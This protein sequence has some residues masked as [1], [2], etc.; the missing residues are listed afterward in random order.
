[1][2]HTNIDRIWWMWQEA[3]PERLYE[4]EGPTSRTPPYGNITLHYPLKMGNVGPT[5]PVG[6]VMD[7]RKEPSCYIYV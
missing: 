5:L 3:C 1:M 6:D 4:I 7:I 2:H